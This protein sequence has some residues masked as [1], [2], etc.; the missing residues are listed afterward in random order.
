MASSGTGS[1]GTFARPHLE[2][3][4]VV[5]GAR[6]AGVADVA[7]QLAG[8][9]PVAGGEP[10]GEPRQVEVAVPH[11]ADRRDAA[12][13]RNRPRRCWR[14][15]STAHRPP[16]RRRAGRAWPAMSTPSWAPAPYSLL[17]APKLLPT[18][19]RGSGS[20]G[21]RSPVGGRRRSVRRSSN[22]L[23]AV[24]RGSTAPRSAPPARRAA[25]RTGSIG[26]E[27]P[28]TATTP[29]RKSPDN[30]TESGARERRGGVTSFFMAD[31]WAAGAHQRD[32]R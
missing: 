7:D 21:N 27:A 30:A 17:M 31:G 5:A 23:G 29:A 1:T 32:G 3:Q 6:V 20:I 25:D 2:V 19:H 16:P 4:V 14:T 22:D 18:M 11:V 9:D 26:D 13:N 15:A 10:V 28:A 8:D 24:G 12:P